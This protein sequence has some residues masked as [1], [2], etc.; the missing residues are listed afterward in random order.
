MIKSSNEQ[1]NEWYNMSNDQQVE[2][3][4]HINKERI[5]S[6]INF[7]INKINCIDYFRLTTNSI[8]LLLY[9]NNN[10]LYFSN[11]MHSN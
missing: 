9:L 7:F 6:S 3:T 5:A 8:K 10:S 4:I 2:W 1:L 11:S